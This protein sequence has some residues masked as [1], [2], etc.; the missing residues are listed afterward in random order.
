MRKLITILIA[1]ALPLSL[2]AS[3]N[4]IGVLIAP[5]W[6]W[7]A[8]EDSGKTDFMFLASG[9]SYFGEDHAIG[10]EYGFGVVFP[11]NRWSGG[12]TSASNEN[13]GCVAK[14]G[15][16]YRYRINDFAGVALGVGC[17]GDIRMVDASRI[18]SIDLYGNTAFDFSIFQI[19]RIGIGVMAGGAI[20]DN[21]AITDGIFVAPFLNVSYL[22]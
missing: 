9:A 14:L 2:Y 22:F 7:S 4:N 19:M 16:E 21:A 20:Y 17:L 11:L 10:I 1:I 3:D 12:L 13:N 8:G 15:L 6:T 5:E 18:C